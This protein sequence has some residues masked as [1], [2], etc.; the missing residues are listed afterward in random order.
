MKRS[1]YR[2]A[3]FAILL[4]CGVPVVGAAAPVWAQAY[5]EVSYSGFHRALAR[6][7][8]WVY[9]DRWGEVWVP[10]VP[11]N[12]RP[13]D[14]NGYWADTSDYGPVWVSDYEWGDITF[15]YGRWVNDP[16]DGWLWLPGYVWSPAWVVW[17]ANDRYTGWMPMPPDRTFLSGGFNVSGSQL[18]FSINFDSVDDYYGYSSWYGR[19]Y[20]DDR[21]AANW[22]F[23]DTRY[24]GDRDFRRHVAPRDSYRDIVRRSRNITNYTIVNNTIV[25]R[26]F[27]GRGHSW[28]RMGDRN[29]DRGGDRNRAGRPDRQRAADVLRNPQLITRVDEGR[30]AASNMRGATPRGTGAAGSAPRPS[31]EAISR[32]SNNVSGRGGR[33]PKNLYTRER[34]ER[35]AVS[36]GPVAPRAGQNR[37]QPDGAQRER[38]ERGQQERT[39][40]PRAQEERGRVDRENVTREREQRGSAA[41]EENAARE[42]DQRERTARAQQERAQQERAQQEKV[43][44][45]RAQQERGQADRETAQREKASR[46]SAAQERSERERV[47]RERDQRERSDRAQTERAQQQQRAQQ[48]RDQ[49]NRNR[50][51]Q[52]Q[53][54]RSKMERDNTAREQQRQQNATQAQ[55]QREQAERSRAERIPASDRPN[56]GGDNRQGR[57]GDKKDRKR[58]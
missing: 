46:E 42:R 56:R 14:T 15:H 10:D 30:R 18:H 39:Q 47:G 4:A 20:G 16:D 51:A 21:F 7:G 25:N 5:A 2:S 19:G 17:R 26:S 11:A 31:A 54:Q 55:Q 32:L 34:M 13:Y 53:E 8:D 41:R 6:H 37:D 3:C 43:Q 36:G 24:I 52:A 28:D 33:E 23:V 49:Q 44:Q 12:F 38:P 48:D 29:R 9:S 40:Q 35:A 1:L 50:A 27:D 58:D 45:Q 22:I 57:D